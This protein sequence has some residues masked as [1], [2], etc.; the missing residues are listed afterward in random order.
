LRDVILHA[1]LLLL[2]CS[3]GSAA[4]GADRRLLDEIRGLYQAEPD[5]IMPPLVVALTHVDQLRPRT[6]WDPPYNLVQPQREK[7]RQIAEAVLA[8]AEDL[9]LATDQLVIP[10]CLRPDAPYN[11][12]EG[13]AP[14]ILE[15]VPQARRVKYLRCLRQ[16]HKDQYW[17]RLWRQGIQSGRFLLRIGTE[18]VRDRKS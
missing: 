7:A 8:V 11:V 12:E 5:R 15:S 10:V 17:R 4:R 14:A 9:A 2:A 18:W 13:L 16:H 6:E 1:D 3:A